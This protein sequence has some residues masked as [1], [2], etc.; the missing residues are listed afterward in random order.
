MT[1]PDDLQVF[2]AGERP[3]L[4]T[5]RALFLS[6]GL[7]EKKNYA[8]NAI[9]RDSVNP[10][11][12][13]DA[14]LAV[15]RT[16]FENNYTIVFG[17]QPSISSMVL[18]VA[19]QFD[20]APTPRVLVFQSLFFW[21]RFP[22][23][24]LELADGKLGARLLIEAKPTLAESLLEMRTV[25]FESRNLVAA[26]FIGGMDGIEAEA[27]LFHAR[28]PTL[29]MFAYGSTGAA[30]E[31]LLDA[32]PQGLTQEDFCGGRF[33]PVPLGALTTKGGSYTAL[34]RTVIAAVHGG[35]AA[36]RFAPRP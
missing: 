35:L 17:A 11:W 13:R 23:A 16:A 26:I 34:T 2:R 19:T 15:T 8:R 20:P 3:E 6:A 12:V 25:M 9:H 29:P 31:D 24:T 10:Q 33:A 18:Q 22:E 5:R 32:P 4:F 7:P 30:S 1:D 28:N 14:V 27:I 21:G 36:G